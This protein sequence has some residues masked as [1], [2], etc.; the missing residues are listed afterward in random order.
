M[1]LDTPEGDLARKPPT[2]RFVAASLFTAGYAPAALAADAS[3]I[4]TPLGDLIEADV[5]VTGAGGYSLPAYLVRPPGAGRRST[6]IVVNEIFGIHAYIKDICKRLAHMGYVACAPDYFDRAGDPSTLT[7]MA[8]I[9]PIVATATYEQTMQDTQG[10][11][12]WTRRQTFSN[13]KFGITGFCWGGAIV[14]M[15]AARCPEIRAGAAWYGRLVGPATPSANDAARPWPI[16]IAARLRTPVLG[17]Y[18]ANDQ[19]I[20]VASVAQM[21]AALAASGNPSHS[22][23]IVYPDA[24]HGFHADYRDSYNA[25]DARDGWGRLTAWFQSAGLS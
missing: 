9:R 20:P 12:D 15:A 22:E 7:D 3:P 2:R 23:L 18:A 17:L 8:A 5:H 24:G 10:A 11:I 6:V 13:G 21:R 19:G 1:R 4:T 14:W 25:A 16:D